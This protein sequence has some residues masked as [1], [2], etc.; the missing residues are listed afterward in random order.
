MPVFLMRRIREVVF[1]SL[2]FG[3]WI[4]SMP[5]DL[6]YFPHSQLYYWSGLWQNWDMFAPQ[7]VYESHLFI[8]NFELPDGTHLKY[9]FPNHHYWEKDPP[10]SPII[11]ERFR[12]WIPEA[13]LKNGNKHLKPAAVR[14][15]AKQASVKQ[16]KSAT[17][18]Q[19]WVDVH[20][21]EPL[22]EPKQYI[23]IYKIYDTQHPDE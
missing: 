20:T 11:L 2:I 1:F 9:T 3:V 4:H 16:F 23:N 6:L 15:A 18:T 17:I 21:A 14:F 19:Y 5:Q 8:A 7:P 13:I 22:R 10:Y 12:K